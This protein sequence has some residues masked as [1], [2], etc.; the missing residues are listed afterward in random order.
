VTSVPLGRATDHLSE[1]VNEVERTHDRVLITRHGQPA[2]VLISPGGLAS[3]EET[4][5]ILTSP[6]PSDAIAEG[7]ADLGAGRIADN[8]ALRNRFAPR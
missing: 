1:Y 5:D 7:L 4:V 2:A 6:G 8:D 3:P